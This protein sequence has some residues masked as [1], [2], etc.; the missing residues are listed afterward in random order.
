[1]PAVTTCGWRGI[2]DPPRS[3]L[4]HAANEQARAGE[5]H[6]RQRDLRRNQKSDARGARR[7]RRGCVRPP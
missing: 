1:M 6:D 5:Q 4:A 2:R 7:G 3:S